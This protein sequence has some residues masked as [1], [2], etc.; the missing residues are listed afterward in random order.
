MEETCEEL[1]NYFA[2]PLREE[3]IDYIKSIRSSRRSKEWLATRAM[4]FV[5]AGD[6][7]SILNYPDGR[8]YLSDRSHLVSISHTRNYAA[9]LLHNSLPI[10]IDIEERSERVKKIA[11][12]FISEREYIDP[13]NKVLHQLLHWSAKE[14]LF[15]RLNLREVDFKEHLF[16]HPFT[17]NNKGTITATESKTSGA[18]RFTVHYEVHNDYVITWTIGS[19]EVTE[20]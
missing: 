12:K 1:L 19:D 18:R 10:G 13:T 16:L 9:L 6:D 14:T 5:L 7:K 17:L 4:L 11:S 15:K 2:E 20:G 8:P 3:A